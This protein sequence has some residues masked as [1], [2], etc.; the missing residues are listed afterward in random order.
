[1]VV[2]TEDIW[3]AQMGDA[4]VVPLYNWPDASLSS[5]LVEVD[6]SLRANC[7]RVQSMAREFIGDWTGE[8]PDDPWNRLRIG[9]RLFLDID[10]RIAM[11]PPHRLRTRRSDWWPRQNNIHFAT[12]TAIAASDKLYGIVSDND[13]NSLPESKTVAAVRLTSKTKPQRLRWEVPVGGGYVV[14]G[15]IYSVAVSDFEQKPPRAG[16]PSRLSDDESAAIATKQQTVL[17]LG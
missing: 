2:L 14:T 7:T 11:T 17:S 9:V 4:V 15:D 1:V 3:N 5:L 16:Y 10:R 8:C 13:W 12:N 6:D